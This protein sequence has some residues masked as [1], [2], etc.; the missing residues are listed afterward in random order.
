[1]ADSPVIALLTD[2][3]DKDGFV[4]AMKGVILSINPKARIVDITHSVTPFCI[5]E[6]ALLL[7]AHYSYFP[8]GTIF[9]GVVDPGV[10]SQRPA[11]AM[12]CQDYYF[13]GPMNGLFDLV[14]R[15]LGTPQCHLIENFTLPRKNQTFHGRDIFAPVA[16]HLSKGVPLKDVGKEIP[17]RTHLV[18]EEPTLSGNTLVGKI[19]YFDRFGN[20]ITNVECGPYREAIFRGERIKVVTHFMEGEPG[21]L[22]SLCGS[23]GLM[24]IFLPMGNAR[25]TYGISLGEEVIFNL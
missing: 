9:V 1:M 12:R 14:V 6:G 8:P 7:M 2:F 17:Y 19:L 21:K 16:A 3:G 25:E 4:G 20:A 18:W 10:G 5:Q 22:G 11:I 24:E 23:F 13:V 15:K